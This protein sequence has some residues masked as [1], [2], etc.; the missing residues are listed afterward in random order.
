LKLGRQTKRPRRR[1]RDSVGVL[2]VIAASGVNP[3]AG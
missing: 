3:A 1:G 2:M